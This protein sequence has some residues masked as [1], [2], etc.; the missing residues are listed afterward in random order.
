MKTLVTGATGF[1]GSHLVEQL[2]KEGNGVRALV[3]RG[4]DAS[5]LERIGVEVVRGDIRNLDDVQRAVDDCPLVF[6]LAK[7][8]GDPVP[9][10]SSHATA[11][12]AENVGLASLRAGVARLV[13][14]SSTTVYGTLRNRAITE[15][16]PIRPTSRGGKARAVCE[17]LLLALHRSDGL[18]CVVARVSSVFGPR[19]RS[20][21]GFF[22]AIATGE[23]RMVGSG[24]N[25]HQPGDVSDI[26]A[27]L[28]LCG[29]APDAEGRVYIITGNEPISLRDMVRLIDE[30]C[31]VTTERTALPHA[32]LR[33]YG[34]LNSLAFA[35]GGRELPRMDSI[36][37]FLSDRA[38][39]LTRAKTELGYAPRVSMKETIRRTV[40]WFRSQ[41]DLKAS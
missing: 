19:V 7:S 4:S 40:E 35:I 32:L 5:G 8:A 41:R 30:E 26:T 14:A 12:G 15:S 3:R 10:P 16:T 21:R 22:E 13:F 37:V 27:G 39:D 1:I 29:T 38:F 18:P 20:W 11:T 9:G 2:V 31:G 6:H 25:Y 34:R 17:E 24:D 36:E 23:F 33:A 28:L